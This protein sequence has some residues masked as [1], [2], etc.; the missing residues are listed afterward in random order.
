M[1]VL[2]F[3][4]MSARLLISH[5]YIMRTATSRVS[6]TTAHRN[7]ES[8]GRACRFYRHMVS[9][10]INCLFFFFLEHNNTCDCEADLYQIEL[11]FR[12]CDVVETIVFEIP[13][14]SQNY[15]MNGVTPSA[16]QITTFLTES[17]PKFDALG[18]IF[19]SFSPVAA[20]IYDEID[21]GRPTIPCRSTV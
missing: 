10:F 19:D 21:A 16:S 6:S 20:N 8:M 5:L 14:A 12:K 1:L 7:A 18:L 17:V 11:N 3:R 13:F 2:S 15:L 9:L 4:D